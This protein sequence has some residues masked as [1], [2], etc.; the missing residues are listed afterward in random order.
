MGLDRIEVF[1][2]KSYQGR[3]TIG[4]FSRFTAVIGPNGAGPA[5][6]GMGF[7]DCVFFFLSLS[8]QNAI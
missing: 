2:F 7:F 5:A 8:S 1:N 3:Q 4:P 6:A